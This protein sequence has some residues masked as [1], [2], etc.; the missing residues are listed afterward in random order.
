MLFL[1]I[2]LKD[3]QV[4][5]YR[6]TSGYQSFPD[7]VGSSDSNGK[8]AAIR[9][10]D[11]LDGLR[12]LD[13]GCNEGFFS[14]EAANRGAV[15]VIGL[16]SDGVAIERAKRRSGNVQFLHQGWSELPAGPFD[17]VLMLSALHYEQD[18]RGLLRRIADLLR[19]DGVLI[20]ET[21]VS[22][23]SRSTVQ[24][25]QRPI[26]RDD[27]VW[28]PTRDLLL[29]RYLEPFVV[30]EVGS[31]VS[32]RGD[33]VRREVFHCVRRR[34]IVLLI[35]GASRLGKTALARELSPS[36]TMTIHVDSI[37]F[38]MG[39]STQQGSSPLLDAV[40]QAFAAGCDIGQTVRAL[41]DAG[42]AVD[43]AELIDSLV[44]KDERVVAVEGYALTDAVTRLLVERLGRRA[45]VW[46][47]TRAEAGDD[48]SVDRRKDAEVVGLQAQILQLQ[49]QL[50]I[51]R[52][53]DVLGGTGGD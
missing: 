32:Q 52:A 45:V 18:P 49:E 51:A 24:W 15:E 44:P 48:I 12:V 5:E 47:V 10:P 53:I 17:V 38:D 4:T 39:H 40:M 25:T 42:R 37:L 23:R 27:V 11:R 16:D 29:Q 7:L 30:R 22:G 21:G 46:T 20:L 41:E 28:Y 13:I 6:S 33:S 14:I 9:L 36:A 50:R 8:L 34:P 35:G 43:L 31:S 3:G 1:T 19:P 2:K 26:V